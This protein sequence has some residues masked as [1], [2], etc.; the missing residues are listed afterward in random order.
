[1]DVNK[2]IAKDNNFVIKYKNKSYYLNSKKINKSHIVTFENKTKFLNIGAFFDKKLLIDFKKFN[3][4]LQGNKKIIKITSIITTGNKYMLKDSSIDI[5]KLVKSHLYFSINTHL[6]DKTFVDTNID[7]K[8]LNKEIK[9]LDKAF[10][11]TGIRQKDKEFF[12]SMANIKL[13][14]IGGKIIIKDFMKLSKSN[15]KKACK[16]ILNVPYFSLGLNEKQI[17]LPRN[18]LLEIISIENKVHTLVAKPKKPEQFKVVK[19]SSIKTDLYDIEAVS[20]LIQKHKKLLIGGG[21]RMKALQAKVRR[22]IESFNSSA[23]AVHP[24]TP[25]IQSPRTPPGTPPGTPP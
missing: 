12:C 3:G 19:D 9:K 14:K 13:Q 17:L 6:V 20:L 18:I 23:S 21:R 8:T 11:E 10:I 22:F 5:G 7:K 15:S 25:P 16:I 24:Q 4:F 2:F 1:M